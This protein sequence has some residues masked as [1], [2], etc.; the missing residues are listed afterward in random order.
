MFADLTSAHLLN[1]K[2]VDDLNERLKVKDVQVSIHNFRPNIVLETTPYA[3]DEWDWV[4]IGDVVFQLV[5]PCTRCV[6][7]TINPETGIKNEQAEPL[8]T[9]RQY[10]ILENLELRKIENY[11]PVMGLNL[12]VKQAGIVHVGDEVWVTKNSS[13]KVMK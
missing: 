3:E 10:H 13:I 12:G 4:K 2:S 5:K 9:L 6:L 8:K 1:K 7:T 11:A